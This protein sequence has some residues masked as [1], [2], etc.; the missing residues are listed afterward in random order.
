MKRRNLQV[1]LMLATISSSCALG[2]VSCLKGS[3]AETKLVCQFPFATGVFANASALGG[4]TGTNDAQRVAAG[5]NTAIATQLSQL[6]IASAS[7]GQVVT[8]KAGLAKS[9]EDLGPILTDRAQTL[10]PNTFYLGVTASQFVFTD[11]DGKSL[12]SLPFSYFRNAYVNGVLQSTI[13]TTEKTNL[14]L[15]ANQL[16]GVATFGIGKRFDASAIVPVVYISIGDTTYSTMNYVVDAATN[17][18][19]FQYAS[20]DSSVP[21]T[22]SGIGDI[23]FN[24]KYSPWSS[25]HAAVALA[26]NLRT[27]TGDELNLLGS[28]AF[29]FNPYVVYSYVSEHFSPHAK[30]GYQ[31]NTATELNI[32]TPAQTSTTSTTSSTSPSSKKSLPGGMTYDVGADFTIHKKL[33]IAI[34]LL[35]NQYLNTPGL[36]STQTSV[37]G[38]PG[39]SLNTISIVN[40]SYTINNVS[41]GF[42]WR[43]SRDLG[44]V[45]SANVLIQLNNV[46]LR[47]RPTP[48]VGISYRWGKD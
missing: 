9:F 27:P 10:G 14:H 20:K 11:V 17:T 34:D 47:S 25:E 33:T 23:T 35:G 1:I 5:L 19:S 8:Y 32:G 28:G 39:G 43:P 15:K 2:Q 4:S 36:Q 37:A 6:P 38:V 46:G 13:Y 16:V 41:T 45:L 30:V 31:W 12:G 48:L 42:K 40:S 26:A 22:A 29:G 44:L 3:T 7:S 24:A 21:G 18:L